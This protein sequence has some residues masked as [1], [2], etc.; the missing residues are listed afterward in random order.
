MSL[1]LYDKLP[2]WYKNQLASV[3]LQI[4][5]TELL[6]NIETEIEVTGDKIMEVYN[7]YYNTIKTGI[8]NESSLPEVDK[9]LFDGLKTSK[10]Y[11]TAIN[12]LREIKKLLPP[13]APAPVSVD[14]RRGRKRKS[15]KR[16]INEYSK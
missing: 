16:K 11:M 10:M 1:T 2:I 12:N 5:S 14:G 3:T 4:A 15:P 8:E 9:L 7:K 13:P 6:N